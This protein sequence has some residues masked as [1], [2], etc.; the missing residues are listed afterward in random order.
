MLRHMLSWFLLSASAGTVNTVAFLACERFVAHVTG[1]VTRFGLQE[2]STLFVDYALVLV[3]F[4]TGAMASGIAIENRYHRGKQPLYA[5]P[6]AVVVA[7]LI[8]VAWAG[9]RGVFGSFGDAGVTL[10]SRVFISVLSFAMGLQNASVATSTGQVVRTTH[11]TG[12]ATDLG[13]RLA[14]AV[15]ARGE[16]RRAATRD[17]ALRA[18][19]IVAFTVGVVIAVPIAARFGYLSFLLPAA[20]VFSATVMSFSH[21]GAL[22]AT[23]VDRETSELPQPAGRPPSLGSSTPACP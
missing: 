1:T 17:A 20:L 8:A 21:S 23:D 5:A 3:C 2:Q 11:L 22:V 12:P 16:A 10:A 18:G 4:I 14:S 9:A 6:L 7:L 15:F 19:K 13:V